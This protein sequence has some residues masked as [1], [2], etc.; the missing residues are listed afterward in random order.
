MYAP[1]RS[2][3]VTKADSAS[4]PERFI[5]AKQRLWS[6]SSQMLQ[7][8]PHPSHSPSFQVL[9]RENASWAAWGVVAGPV[10]T[11]SSDREGAWSPG[12]AKFV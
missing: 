7:R 4:S 2:V 8:E 3:G 12:P 11:S 6:L 1:M 10:A 9:P 5:L